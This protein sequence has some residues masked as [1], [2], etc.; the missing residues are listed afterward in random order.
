MCCWPTNHSIQGLES[1]SSL[2]WNAP[3]R[4]LFRRYN[5]VKQVSKLKGAETFIDVGCGAGDLACTLVSKLGM[6][7]L[8]TDFNDEAIM[9]AKKLR[10]SYGLDN[11]PDFKKLDGAQVK[12]LKPADIVFCMEV[13]EHVKD[14]GKLLNDLIS[15]SKK[16]VVISVPA[17]QNLFTHSDR[18]AGHYRR[19]EKDD[20]RNMLIRNGLEIRSFISYGYPFTNMLRWLRELVSITAKRKHGLATMENR[21]KKSGTDLLD[22]NK[23]FSS[24]LK[25]L[26]YPMYLFSRLFNRTNLGEGYLIICEK[27]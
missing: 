3:P 22:I 2:P 4:Y 21:S 7:G 13:L 26:I 14:D 18:L 9:T 12:K 16:Y 19:Y 23:Y 6:K 17:K 1:V 20:L 10:S 8:G 15:L 5:I 24:W 25:Y 27:R 11:M